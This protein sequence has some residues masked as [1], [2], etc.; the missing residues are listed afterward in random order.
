MNFELIREGSPPID[1]KFTDRTRYYAAFDSYY[2]DGDAG[3]MTY[4]IAGYAEKRLDEYLG[5]LDYKY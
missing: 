3:K 1:I 2:R 4:L 5:V